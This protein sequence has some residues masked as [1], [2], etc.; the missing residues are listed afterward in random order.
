MSGSN[1][2]ISVL[3]PAYNH[4]K[5][6]AETIKSIIAQ[7]Y[8]NIELI[9]IDDGS[10]DNTFGIIKSMQSE[11][12]K[13]FKNI[14][15][16]TQENA[17]TSE[18]LNKLVNKASGKYIYLIASDD[19][20][21]ENAIETLCKTLENDGNIVLAVGDNEYIDN[22]S[23]TIYL[24]NNKQT[25]G[26]KLQSSNK[27]VNFQDD[28]F[29]SYKS[30][31]QGNYIPNGYLFRKSIIDKHAKFTKEAPL[32]DWYLH[33]QLS[34]HGKFKYI[35]KILFSYRWHDTNTVK[36]NERMN[37]F[38]KKTFLHE[39]Q[40]VSKPEYEKFYHIYQEYKLN[41]IKKSKYKLGDFFEV[42]TCNTY[43]LKK[44][45]IKIFNIPICFQ[46]I[47]I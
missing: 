12:E 29:G 14:D 46:T 44:R 19:V 16:T 37:T 7:T 23:Q 31:V 2:L 38:A 27:H 41:G 3:I 35:D 8:D 30:L 28:S 20:A 13:R 17:G 25:F 43:C 5:Y 21:K 15:F 18:T 36:N 42:Y 24:N 1:P 39:E 40:I 47:H 45:Y 10:K 4:D 33:L 11:C 22:N 6:I 32:E 9:I 26:Q 34:K